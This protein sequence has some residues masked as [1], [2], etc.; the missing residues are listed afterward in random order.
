MLDPAIQTF[1][2]ERQATWLKDKLKS[3][4]DEAEQQEVES[5]ANE[6]YS[7][8]N[9]LPDAAKRAGQLAISSHPPKFSHPSIKKE[10]IS[11]VIA[12]SQRIKDGFLRTG[13]THADLDVFGNAA[14]LDV[15]TFL[16]LK[17]SDGQTVLSH[18]EQDSEV[19]KTQFNYIFAPAIKSQRDLFETP[20]PHSVNTFADIRQGLLAIKQ[21]DSKAITS[22]KLKQIY[23]PV[24]ENYHLLSILTPSGLM[25]KL[26][27]RIN[28]IRFSDAT[29]L[30]REHRRNQEHHEQGFDEL[31]N[32][33]VIGFGGTKPQNIS[34]LNNQFGGTAYLLS[35][36][37]PQLKLRGL[38]TPKTDFFNNSLYYKNYQDSFKALHKLLQADYNNVNIREGRD[39][40]LNFIIKQ[41]MDE[42][43]TEKLWQLRQLEAGWS[44][45]TQL[46]TAQ[47]I[48]LDAHYSEQR[49]SDDGWLNEVIG[50][51]ARWFV[52]SYTKTI[53]K[54]QAISLGDIEL[55]HF[56]QLLADYQED[57][58]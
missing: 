26:K 14:A 30:A 42:Q 15:L 55:A 19:I 1:L 10:K 9:W 12:N 50:D 43:V 29:K 52:F 51:F 13:N 24:D 17:L 5:K 37:P 28:T 53:G 18:L 46:P 33:T 56:K 3:C 57:L 49:E 16:S 27:E 21:T 7:L 35:S 2:S 47:K 31:Y 8:S 54:D 48:W 41:A 25:F 40:L 32:L 20:A 39:N 23:F 34:V 58:R 6:K 44:E 38:Q 4:K 11:A 45:N 36:M 22:E